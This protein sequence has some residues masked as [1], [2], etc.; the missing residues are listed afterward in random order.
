MPMGSISGSLSSPRVDVVV[1]MGHPLLNRT[2]DGFLRIGTVGVVKAVAEEAHHFSSHGSVSHSWL[3][4]MCEEGVQ[5]GSVAG[6]YAGMEYGVAKIRG[7][8]DWK[9]AM[10]SG[11]LTGAV[12]ATVKNKGKRDDIVK[13]AIMGGALATA[14]VFLNHI[15]Y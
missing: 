11:A 12:L 2:V 3:K 7:R 4:K 14:S 6:V 10:I 1:D 15:T 5:W 8:Y 13:D 9:N